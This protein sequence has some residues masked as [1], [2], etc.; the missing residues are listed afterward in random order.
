[1]DFVYQDLKHHDPKALRLWTGGDLDVVLENVN[2]LKASGRPYALRV[3]VIP[4][5]N[6][7]PSDR[8]AIVSLVG[9]SPVEYLPYN[10][11]A[12]TKYPML[13]RKYPLDA[14]D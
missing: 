3:P 13:G 11:A 12:G 9:D 1:M 14:V 5:V 4:G 2:W 10:R 8:A 6:D 7:S